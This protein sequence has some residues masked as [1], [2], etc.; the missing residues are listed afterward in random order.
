MVARAVLYSNGPRLV[1]PTGPLIHLPNDSDLHAGPNLNRTNNT[2]YLEQDDDDD[3]GCVR[4]VA[5]I[6]SYNFI[7]L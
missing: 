3:S 2:I 4:V 6:F 7:V 1:W 5:L